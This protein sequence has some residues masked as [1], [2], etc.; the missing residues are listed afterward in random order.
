MP[1]K[2]GA[3]GTILDVSKTVATPQPAS[4]VSAVTPSFLDRLRSSLDTP[5]ADR[6][7]WEARGRGFLSGAI[8][9]VQ[10]MGRGLADVAEHPMTALPAI[11]RA[12]SGLLAGEGGPTG[13]L[14]AGAGE[15]AAE[16][17]EGSLW[18][19]SPLRSLAKVGTAAGIGMVPMAS[20]VKAGRAISSMGRSAAYSGL[21]ETAREISA[22]E[23]ID[24]TRIGVSTVT[25]GITGGVLGKLLGLGKPATSGSFRA[26]DEFNSAYPTKEAY[27][28]SKPPV[29]PTSYEIQPTAQTGEGTG[30]LNGGKINKNKLT[31]AEYGPVVP[32]KPIQ[33]T[34]GVKLPAQAAHEPESRTPYGGGGGQSADDIA[35]LSE[36]AIASAKAEGEAAKLIRAEREAQRVES[37]RRQ[38]IDEGA[39]PELAYSEKV[40]APR[41]AGGTGTA[42]TKF[43]KPGGEDETGG[44][45]SL[46]GALLGGAKP[47]TPP[48]EAAPP[49]V[50]PP[51]AVAATAPQAS[52]L[53]VEPDVSALAKVL[54]PKA[55]RQAR[56]KPSAVEQFNKG[57][58]DTVKYAEASPAPV[59]P[60]KQPSPTA[61]EPKVIPAP[62]PVNSEVA[63]PVDLGTAEP[64]NLFKS[65]VDAAGQNY[66]AAKADKGGNPL[67]A[68]QAGV[69]LNKEAAA[70]GL[71]TKG[72][73]DLGKFLTSR[74]QPELG[75]KATPAAPAMT[76]KSGSGSARG[77]NFLDDLKAAASAQPAA[78]PAAPQ[79][80]DWIARELADVATRKRG[81]NNQEGFAVPAPVIGGGVGALIGAPLGA[82]MSNE[83]HEGEGAIAGGL[84][85][86][87]LG[88]GAA[89][90]VSH[91]MENGVKESLQDVLKTIP[92][93]QRFSMLSSNPNSALA[94]IFA[95]PW[96]SG[97]VMG[98]EKGL[99]GDS[100]GWD[101]VKRMFNPK[102]ASDFVD[103]M[104]LARKQIGR[105]EGEMLQNDPTIPEQVMALPGTSMT[106]GDMTVRSPIMASG[107]SEEQA[108]RATLT[109]EP[110]LFLWKKLAD[111]FKGTPDNPNDMT[112]VAAD[113]AFPFKRTPANIGE[114]GS[115][116]FPGAG[117]AFQAMRE[118]PD[119]LREQIVQQLMNAGIG[120]GSYGLG[121]NL[122]P[123]TA[124]TVRKYVSNLAGPHSMMASAGFAAGQANRAGRPIV[125][126]KTLQ[127]FADI[128]PLPTHQALLDWM[129]F[130][131]GLTQGDVN[132]PK[133]MIPVKDWTL[134]DPS[135]L[136]SSSS[137]GSQPA[138]APDQRHV[139]RRPQ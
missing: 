116:R 24:P 9:G 128:L 21:G 57:V 135:A 71:P 34:G 7:E 49:A 37:A 51:P 38:A 85:G 4:G 35:G 58:D 31:G 125:G 14:I 81:M 101:L 48:V 72:P 18:E 13:G 97:M 131:S 40:S 133:G 92:K 42:T 122:D 46:L 25:G 47:R 134:P 6:G 87:G 67:A 84:A 22:G 16:G 107:F 111:M 112:K 110:E 15:L 108:R 78:P 41:P 59:A 106:A 114:Q 126:G 45:E 63:S 73:T 117:F 109:G 27:L 113:M 119:P 39:E 91:M 138:V 105:A 95:G 118:H 98:L 2:R 76:N 68:R 50:Q 65:P 3:D 43:V 20:T 90:G 62:P 23:G 94:N 54:K 5:T 96:G 1:L 80:E 99:S 28:A 104:P 61:V 123:E 53:P 100:R 11:T 120:V 19:Q 32:P 82:A 66:R 74:V 30:T 136:M 70:A 124:K 12:G 89:A 44:D 10:K 79:A 60:I 127:E 86:A 69:S 130:G 75:G 17:L 93:W 29:A 36:D 115:F 103:N 102:L 33:A 8:E 52:L 132:I 139:L 77:G 137:S 55:A 56:P 83:G 88:L 64:L 26:G 129:K 121:S